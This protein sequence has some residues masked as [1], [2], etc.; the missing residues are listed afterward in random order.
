MIL[1]LSNN[2]LE[3][4]F[5]LADVTSMEI[6][7]KHRGKSRTFKNCSL[8]DNIIYQILPENELLHLKRFANKNQDSFLKKRNY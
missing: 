4:D 6:E 2:I 5:M 8:K 3:N 1:G 7:L